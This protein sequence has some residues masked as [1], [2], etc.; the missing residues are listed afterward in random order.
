[1]KYLLLFFL[2]FISHQVMAFKLSPMTQSLKI[3]PKK[4]SALFYVENQDK[5][6]QAIQVSMTTRSF[7]K[8]GEEINEEVGDDFLIFPDQLILKPGQK[9]AIKVTYTKDELVKTEKAFRFIAEQLPL[10]LLKKKKGQTTNIKILLKYRAAFYVTPAGAKPSLSIPKST[11]QRKGKMLNFTIS[12]M[13]DAHEVISDYELLIKSGSKKYKV[14]HENGKGV[15]GEN[16]LA[17]SM[18]SFSIQLP[19]SLREENSFE[20]EIIKK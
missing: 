2:V 19:K 11:I 18:R 9:R 7:G 15:I 1:M 16:M 8:N 20:I 13:G 5:L 14:N 4:R 17:K 10:D 6:P 12:N 3:S